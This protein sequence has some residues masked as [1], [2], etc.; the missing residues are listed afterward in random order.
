MSLSCSFLRERPNPLPLK[1]ASEELVDKLAGAVDG[2]REG[3]RFDSTKQPL[4]NDGTP[5]RSAHS[6]PGNILYKAAGY[7]SDYR[8]FVARSVR[9]RTLVNSGGLMMQLR[10]ASRQKSAR[11]RYHRETVGRGF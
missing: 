4:T 7:L 10:F 9:Q 3:R 5:A 6:G 8:H 1:R 2:E 11:D